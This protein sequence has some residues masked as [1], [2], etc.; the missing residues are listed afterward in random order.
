MKRKRTG[1]FREIPARTAVILALAVITAAAVTTTVVL[2]TRRK[3]PALSGLCFSPYQGEDR[4]SAS[5]VGPMIETIAPYAG[6]IRTF[7]STGEWAEAT[8]V[9]RRHGLYTAAGAGIWSDRRQNAREV[10]GLVELVKAGNVDLAVVGD[11]LLMWEILPEDKLIS[12]IEEVRAAGVPTATSD[13][14]DEFISRPGLMEA[15]DVVV[16]NVFPFWEGI[17]VSEAVEYIDNIYET[18]KSKAGGK[19]VIV[20]TGWP[21]AGEPKEEAVPGPVNAAR[22]L[23][24]FTSWARAKGVRYFYFEAFDEP[25]KLEVEGPVGPHWGLWDKDGAIKPY[26]RPIL[27]GDI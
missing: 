1:D 2:V 27:N 22:F 25:W 6:G 20:E 26:A 17:S 7:G 24:D 23:N 3:A 21:S 16:I 19:E 9:A 15:V 8:E 18:V 11:E 12:Y 4:S 5:P 14:W 13:S 10:A